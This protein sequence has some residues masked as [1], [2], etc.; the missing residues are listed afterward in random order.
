MQF[1]P[2][3]N[4]QSCD[5]KIFQQME[6]GC[7][8]EA[9]R[10]E[11]GQVAMDGIV[12]FKC[13]GSRVSKKGA[14]CK[15]CNGTGQVDGAFMKLVMDVVREEIHTFAPK[16][17][18]ELLK[19][20]QRKRKLKRS[21][22][23]SRIEHPNVACDLCNVCPIVGVR[24][25]CAVCKDFDMCARCEAT[26]GHQHPLLKIRRPQQAP[27][28]LCTVLDEDGPVP[29][30]APVASSTYQARDVFPGQ[31][32]KIGG[33]E[34]RAEVA[35]EEEMPPA[36]PKKELTAENLKATVVHESL[37]AKTKVQ[38]GTMFEKK[39]KLKNTGREEWPIGARLCYRN[40]DDLQANQYA[41]VLPV[42]PGQE[43]EATIMMTA[44]VKPGN[45]LAF[46]RLGVR[47]GD[48]EWLFGDKMNVDVVVEEETAPR[49][50]DMPRPV[51]PHKFAL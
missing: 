15:R 48:E 49:S 32:V 19:E 47:D 20:S 4:E 45:Y 23:V 35:K 26:K 50:V 2:K 27:H 24:Y 36:K 38:K 18:S 43:V 30:P 25:K 8:S 42:R 16:L 7:Q 44:P 1:M 3:T 51:V 17:F 40:G 28:F 13:E 5:P 37:P 11:E 14:P 41:L 21:M 29:A 22:E 10:D 34:K 39:W 33:E 12:C 31:P 9:G 46:F 6:I